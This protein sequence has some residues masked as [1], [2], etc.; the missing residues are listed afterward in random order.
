MSLANLFSTLEPKNMFS[1]ESFW[2]AN[3]DSHEKIRERIVALS[4][5]AGE[6]IQISS[7]VL[8]PVTDISFEA[9][10][11]IHQQAHNEMNLILGL[12]GND[13]TGLD[14]EDPRALEAFVAL[15]GQNHRLAE[16]VLRIT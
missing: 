8:Y 14:L 16:D 6:I 10:E 13:Y 1:W 7:F 15:H 12:G 2:F 11:Q 5:E 4:E 3:Q 9:F